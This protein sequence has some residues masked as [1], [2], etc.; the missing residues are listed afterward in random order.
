VK[1]EGGA[2]KI[3]LDELTDWNEQRG[4]LAASMVTQ[5]EESAEAACI[6]VITI[7]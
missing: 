5:A 4:R 6:N 1:Y 3:F 2:K 7:L